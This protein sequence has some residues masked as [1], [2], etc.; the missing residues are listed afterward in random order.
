[1][2]TFR[3]MTQ[4][5]MNHTPG[6]PLDPYTDLVD[7]VFRF[8]TAV[9]DLLKDEFAYPFSVGSEALREPRGR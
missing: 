4:N 2:C 8:V 5:T 6:V 1:M 3:Q 7:I 9:E